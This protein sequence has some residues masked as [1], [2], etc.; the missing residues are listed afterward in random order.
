MT[1]SSVFRSPIA[2]IGCTVL[3]AVACHRNPAPMPTCTRAMTLPCRVNERV[4]VGDPTLPSLHY[5]APAE[6]PE[7]EE[8]LI[9]LQLD[10]KQVTC[11]RP[12]TPAWLRTEGRVQLEAAIDST[13]GR[14][15]PE[16]ITHIYATDPRLDSLARAAFAK[17][18]YHPR[19]G[20]VP[21]R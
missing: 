4:T 16:T 5:T 12:A 14:V 8:R 17:C 1:T 10:W 11:P 3:A 19:T 21:G 7:G 18:V 13:N 15:E 6:T 20:V 9:G 2:R